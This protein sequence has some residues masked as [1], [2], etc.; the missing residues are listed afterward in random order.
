MIYYRLVKKIYQI[1]AKKMCRKCQ[2]F[3][4]K[5]AKILDLGCGSGIISKEF[6][7]YFGAELIGVDIVD[8]RVI[9][10]PFQ[11]VDGRNLPFPDHSFDVVLISYVLH[12][13][14]DPFSLLKEAKR[15][16]EKIII[17]EDLPEGFFSKMFCQIHRIFFDNL[18][19]NPSKTSFKTEKEWGRLFANLQLNILA[20]KI[21]HIFPV[22]KILF[23]LNTRGS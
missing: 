9:D 18:F 10:I 4:A 1:A 2:N 8:R 19:Q 17:F 22:K 20:Q 3:I 12:H 5:G 23:V 15:V 11:L 14:L 6:Q 7:N 13:S 16:G 21:I